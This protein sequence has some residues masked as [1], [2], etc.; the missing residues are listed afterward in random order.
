VGKDRIS[1]VSRSVEAARGG[2]HWLFGLL[3][4]G[5]RLVKTCSRFR[6]GVFRDRALAGKP[7]DQ[8]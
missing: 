3:S 1:I 5:V 4:L 6:R 2:R 8:L 7:L